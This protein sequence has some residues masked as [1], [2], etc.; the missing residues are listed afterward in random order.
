MGARRPNYEP[1]TFELEILSF[2]RN[3]TQRYGQ[4]P[5]LRTIARHFNVYPNAIRY[6]LK[7]L[8]EKGH[9]RARPDRPVTGRFILSA[10]G[11]SV[12]G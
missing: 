6:H 7:N 3:F 5:G 10:K 2:H 4:A 9:I 11:R 1:T 12:A 8:I